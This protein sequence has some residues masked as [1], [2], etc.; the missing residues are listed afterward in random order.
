MREGVDLLH[1]A[2][3]AV[4]SGGAVGADK[5]HAGLSEEGVVLRYPYREALRL[6]ALEARVLQEAI[7]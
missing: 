5:V 3:A 7:V 6:R 2:G 1:G 4:Q